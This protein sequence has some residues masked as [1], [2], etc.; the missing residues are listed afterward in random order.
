MEGLSISLIWDLISRLFSPVTKLL[1]WLYEKMPFELRKKRLELGIVEARWGTHTWNR[2][3]RGDEEVISIHT[4]WNITNILPYNVTV[5]NAYLRKPQ[6]VKGSVLIKSHEADIY[7]SCIIPQGYTTEVHADFTID[8]KYAKADDKILKISIDF[9]DSLG[10]L[11]KVKNASVYLVIKNK[12]KQEKLTVEDPSKIK[13]EL[14]RK[15][16]AVLKNEI[17]QYKIRGRLEGRLGTVEWP[18]GTIEW[19]DV[20]STIQ[21]LFQSSDS[22]HVTSEHATALLNLYKSAN[23]KGK[24]TI[25][26]ALLDRIDRKSE[27]RNVSYLIIFALFLSGN[28]NDGLVV[29]K[30]KLLNDK[31]NGFSDVLR[32]IDLLLAFR[33]QEFGEDTLNQLEELVYSIEE[34]PFRIKERI[35]AIRVK[36]LV[37]ER[38]SFSVE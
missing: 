28:L 6:A 36:S 38:P 31:T 34:H 1:K 14:V 17:Q 3:K 9:Q 12:I 32:L 2:G 26:K 10:H 13:D 37:G 33:Y 29:A 30:R 27:Y 7:G 20:G 24:A 35:N 18:R 15:V 11:H 4:A 21:F 5:L 25:T 16:V 23:R 19:T 22:Q 8:S